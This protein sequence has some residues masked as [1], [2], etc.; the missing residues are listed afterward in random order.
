MGLIHKLPSALEPLPSGDK[1]INAVDFVVNWARAN[2]LWPLT[3]GTSCCAIEMMAASMPRY[4]IARFG[5]EVFRASPRQADLIIL[6]GTIVDKMADP[7]LTLYE[8]MPGPKYVIA[9]GACTISGGPFVY[10]NYSVVQGADRVIPV[11]VFIPGCPPRPEALLEGLMLLQEKIKKETI[12][13]PW[14]TPELNQA[15]VRN[16]HAEAAKAWAELEKLKDIEMADARAKFKEENPEY[17]APKHKKKAKDKFEAQERS[18]KSSTRNFNSNIY[19]SIQNL[20]PEVG[21]YSS[22]ETE[23]VEFLTNTEEDYILDIE[24][25]L[26][27]YHQLIKKL[28]SDFNLKYLIELTAV[29]WESHIDLIVHLMNLD[30][31]QKVFIRSQINREQPQAPTISDI[32]KGANWHEREVYD[33]FGVQFENHP[34]LRRLFL[35]DDFKGHPLLKDFTHPKIIKRPY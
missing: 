20:F 8:Q 35:K 23:A 26:I 5:S 22:G 11:D 29:D 34:D 18:I 33:F 17:K 28:E 31:G 30:N 25:P 19:L 12:R 6:A 21:L 2:S 24:V 9:M 32:Y 15:P 1:L 16:R 14:S 13:Q 27:D 3:Y 10:D 7:L 4:D